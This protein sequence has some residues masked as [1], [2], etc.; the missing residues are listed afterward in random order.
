MTLLLKSDLFKLKRS[1]SFKVCL[2]VA[3]ALGITMAVLYYFAWNAMQDKLEETARMIAEMGD[4]GNTI[5]D[6]LALMPQNDLWSYVNISLSDLNVLYITA[7]V[8]GVFVGSEYSMGTLRNPITRGFS[9][10]KMYFSKLIVTSIA[11]MAVIGLYTLGGTLAGMIM[12]GFSASVTAGEMLLTILCYF[13]LFLAVNSFYLMVVALTKKT[14]YSIAFSL[15][16][17]MLIMSLA[18]V[19]KIGYA[20]FDRI[21][22]LWVFD[23]IVSTQELV[24]SSEVYIPIIAAV[25]YFVLFTVLG[26]LLFRRQEIK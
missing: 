9:R 23:T 12:F 16:I 14:G 2:I 7:V 1:L 24:K 4:Y 22:R 26:L 11:S 25:V 3:F 20:D 19:I 8:V 15:I 6:A 18:R 17:P 5:K 13:L 21:S 10:T